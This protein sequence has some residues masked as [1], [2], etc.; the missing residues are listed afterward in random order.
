MFTEKRFRHQSSVLTDEALK[1]LCGKKANQIQTVMCL[2][3]FSSPFRYYLNTTSELTY[4]HPIGTLRPYAVPEGVLSITSCLHLH[5]QG[6][7]ST[8]PQLL[9]GHWQGH[10]EAVEALAE[11]AQ[12]T[13]KQEPGAVPP[14]APTHHHAP[15]PACME[16][17]ASSSL[18]IH[19]VLIKHQ[20]L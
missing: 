3:T 2:Q 11:A 14:L 10:A 16:P 19:N 20:K 13:G 18:A 6:A 7:Y 15:P 5:L 8:G 9:P 17:T 4:L 12:T 1:Q